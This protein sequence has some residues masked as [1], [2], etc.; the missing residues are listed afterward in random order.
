MV[1]CINC[2]AEQL[3]AV[4]TKSRCVRLKVFSEMRG[5]FVGVYR[6]GVSEGAYLSWYYLFAAVPLFL[7][8]SLVHCAPLP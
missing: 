7:R 6:R 2:A 3:T 5:G 1:L 4:N 8:S